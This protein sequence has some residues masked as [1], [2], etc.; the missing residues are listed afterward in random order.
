MIK[1]ITL[2]AVLAAF[3]ATNAMATKEIHVGTSSV[4]AGAFGSGIEYSA[5]WA[6]SNLDTGPG[7][8]WGVGFDLGYAQL[9]TVDITS[10][11]TDLKLG[12]SPIKDLA[13]FVI[14]TG[15][16]QTIDSTNAYGFGYGAGIDYKFAEHFAIGAEY[17]TYTMTPDVGGYA[18]VDYTY[19]KMGVNLKYVF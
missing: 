6:G 10:F 7:I 14:G 19:D 3:L 2:G 17:K 4:D 1:K 12:Y 15:M 18:G 13:V 5:G 8:F 11:S 9:D 16:A